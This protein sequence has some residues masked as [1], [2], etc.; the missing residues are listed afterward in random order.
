MIWSQHEDLCWLVLSLYSQDLLMT[1]LE[2]P[3]KLSN[4]R[5]M[6]TTLFRSSQAR[7]SSSSMALVR[8]FSSSTS[9]R[10]DSS[11][12][13]WVLNSPFS[14]RRQSTRA[15]RS[16]MSSAFGSFLTCS[17]ELS[18][19]VFSSPAIPC[20]ACSSARYWPFNWRRLST[21]GLK[22]L[23]TQGLISSF[24]SS[25]SE[26]TYSFRFGWGSSLVASRGWS[27]CGQLPLPLDRTGGD[28]YGAR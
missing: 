21:I 16:A 6:A 9:F 27:S 10:W 24:C 26:G 4:S 18:G 2:G 1:L 11:S 13:T 14:L 7:T 23:R 3:M 5:E 28:P 8:P 20:G 22:G 17:R 15:C 19:V 12:A 25:D